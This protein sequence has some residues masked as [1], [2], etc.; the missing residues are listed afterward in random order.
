MYFMN[1]TSDL[2]PDRELTALSILVDISFGA[3]WWAADRL[4][5]N[6]S[7]TFRLNDDRIGHPL[8]SVMREKL[9]SRFACVPMLL[10]TSGVK[11]PASAKAACVVVVGLTAKDPGH[12]TY[13]GSDIVPGLYG[14]DDLYDAIRAKKSNFRSWWAKDQAR[15]GHEHMEPVA[16]YENHTMSPNHDKPRLDEDETRRLDGF[17]KLHNL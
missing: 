12:R 17:C 14:F 8:V 2:L 4:I 7:P 15:G 3:L 13:F 1:A 16:W 11:M 10:G 6:K 9:S 5:K